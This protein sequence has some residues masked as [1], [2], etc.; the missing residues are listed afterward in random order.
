MPG[1]N[2]DM[3][4][5]PPASPSPGPVAGRR[6]VGLRF[7]CCGVYTRVYINRGQT[8]YEGCCPKCLQRVAIKIGP[9]GTDHRFFTVR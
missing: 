4:S 9:G 3:A 1:E 7:A 5:D 8:A 2:F 6:Y